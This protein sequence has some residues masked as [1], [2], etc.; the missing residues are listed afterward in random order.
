MKGKYL[1]E[2][3]ITCTQL[4]YMRKLWNQV[5]WHNTIESNQINK[6]WNL[7]VAYLSILGVLHVG[8]IRH[9]IRFLCVLCL[10][11]IHHS[12]L[13]AFKH[14]YILKFRK[15]AGGE[16]NQGKNLPKSCWSSSSLLKSHLT[17]ASADTAQGQCLTKTPKTKQRQKW[18]LQR[19]NN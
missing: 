3:A 15:G 12:T 5:H 1:Q 6:V 18:L 16:N 17:S 2:K 9:C 14:N 4:G 10:W 13:P 7:I 19:Q 8:V 11:S